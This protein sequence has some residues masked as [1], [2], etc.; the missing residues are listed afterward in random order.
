MKSSE[1]VEKLKQL[2]RWG[3]EHCEM[4]HRCLTRSKDTKTGTALLE[5]MTLKTTQ[6]HEKWDRRFLDLALQIASWSKDTSTQVGC[7]IV[8]QTRE[9]ISTGFNGLPRGL[10]DATPERSE[11]PEKY[12]WYEHGERNAIYS[13]ARRGVS[14]SGATLY[15]STTPNQLTVCTDCARGIIQSGIARVV[16][17]ALD[18]GAQAKWQDSVKRVRIMFNEAGVVY[19]TID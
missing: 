15:V 9:I 13:A 11:R 16:Q 3:D 19:D 7:V 14:V 8:N 6:T 5:T 17:P 2:Q 12:H 4:K 18:V 1:F 10:E